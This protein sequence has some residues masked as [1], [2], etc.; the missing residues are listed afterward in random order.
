[1]AEVK[2]NCRECRGE[3][4]TAQSDV[5]GTLVPCGACNGTGKKTWGEIADISDKLDAIMDKC[6]DIFERVRE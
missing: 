3:G 2:K 1:M 6:N 4:A 5:D